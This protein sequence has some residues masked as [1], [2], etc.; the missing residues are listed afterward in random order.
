MLLIF[1]FLAS[2]AIINTVLFME[3][4]K[5]KRL[6]KRHIACGEEILKQVFTT[7]TAKI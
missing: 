5:R 7:K 1:I 2:S 6:R 3:H 4:P